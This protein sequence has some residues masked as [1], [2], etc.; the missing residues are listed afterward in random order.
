LSADRGATWQEARVPAPISIYGHALLPNGE[1][2]LVGQGG[3][4]LSSRDGGKNLNIVRREGR[5]SLTDIVV[6]DDGRWMLSSD[7]GLQVR[8]PASA[9]QSQNDGAA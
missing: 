1:L 4:V 8:T 6:T 7:G 2:L 9:N 5:A 3:I